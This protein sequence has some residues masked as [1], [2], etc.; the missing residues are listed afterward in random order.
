MATKAVAVI[1]GVGAG[2]VSSHLQF[3]YII[4]TILCQLT[5]WFCGQGASIARKFGQAYSVAVL[6]RNPA[7]YEP[8][9]EEIT[10][11]GGKAIGISTDVSSASSVNDAFS[12]ISK[13]FPS[14]PLAAA[15]YNVGGGFIRKPFL[16]LSQDEFKS[17]YESNGYVF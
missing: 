6:A 11:R 5:I 1:A 9:V 10:S 7:N 3:L 2:T 4:T 13:A 12:Q 8:L 16:D 14:A 15:I 17:G